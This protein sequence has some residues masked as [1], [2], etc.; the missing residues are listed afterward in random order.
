MLKK[1]DGKRRM[2]HRRNANHAM[3]LYSAYVDNAP[4]A[5]LIRGEHW[6]SPLTRGSHGTGPG[7]CIC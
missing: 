7:G 6:I 2:S 3:L 4:P 5:P 1:L